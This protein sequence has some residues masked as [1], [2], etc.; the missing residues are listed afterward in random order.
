MLSGLNCTVLK[1]A[2]RVASMVPLLVAAFCLADVAAAQEPT[3]AQKSAIKANCRSDF[4]ANCSGVPRGGPEALQC[5]K[6]NVAS[7]SPGCRRL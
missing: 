3:D 5:L 1:F 7:L 4:M 6:K 2:V